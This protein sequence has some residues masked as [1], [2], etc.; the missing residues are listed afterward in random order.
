LEL[1]GTRSGPKEGI[2]LKKEKLP[3]RLGKK[4]GHSYT[5]G[6]ILSEGKTRQTFAGNSETS[7]RGRE[8]KTPGGSLKEVKKKKREGPGL[9]KEEPRAL[10]QGELRGAI[11]SLK[12]WGGAFESL[13]HQK[14]N[15]SQF[16]FL[17]QFGEG[18]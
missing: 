1:D 9:G 14:E 15:N 11:H 7:S 3:R 16:G 2:S 4:G 12:G 5:Y 10:R 17:G 8:K 13:H 6:R 18:S